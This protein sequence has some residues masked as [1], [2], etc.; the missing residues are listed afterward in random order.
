M[1][2]LTCSS[3]CRWEITIIEADRAKFT[4]SNIAVPSDAEE[5]EQV[6]E[7]NDDAAPP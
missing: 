6:E 2:Q 5:D 4:G 1:N 3:V 7:E